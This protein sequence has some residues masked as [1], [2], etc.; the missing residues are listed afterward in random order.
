MPQAVSS[1]AV[2]RAL[3]LLTLVALLGVA[4]VSAGL[5]AGTVVAG[6]R[7]DALA[8]KMGILCAVI[9]LAA[10]SVVLFPLAAERL[11]RRLLPFPRVAQRLVQMVEGLR[12][13]FAVLRSPGQLGLAVLWSAGLWL[14]NAYSFYIA[15]AAFG[16]TV[17][18]S[19]ALLVQ[20]LIA[21]GVAA[22]STPGYFGVFE[23]VTSA[24]LGLFGVPTAVGFA[25]GVT[26]HITTFAPITLLGLASLVRTGLHVRDAT[27][28]A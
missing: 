9:F 5:P 22:P 2:E 17:G 10:V 12:A 27:T 3:D 19:G 14:L 11:I 6:V 25:Y 20:T 21:F 13:G 8:L 16:I 28:Q 18:Y 26:Y 7:L 23:F 1:I 4:L 15:F 24:A